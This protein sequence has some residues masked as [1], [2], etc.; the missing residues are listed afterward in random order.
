MAKKP[1]YKIGDEVDGRISG[2]YWD[3]ERDEI[4]YRISGI[5]ESITI[6]EKL[7]TDVEE[8]A[9]C[10]NDGPHY[11]IGDK[12]G[13]GKRIVGVEKI[14]EDSYRYLIEE[15]RTTMV[16]EGSLWQE[17]QKEMKDRI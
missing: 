10:S 14:G 17:L 12:V 2:I 16:G 1:K 9:R 8:I 7:L 15:R 11:K 3:S 6:G 4:V 13:A 5:D